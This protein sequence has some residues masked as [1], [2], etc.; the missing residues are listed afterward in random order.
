M[1]LIRN[2]H[3]GNTNK[4]NLTKLWIIN[5]FVMWSQDKMI[6]GQ[7]FEAASVKFFFNLHC[8]RNLM[9][10]IRTSL[11]LT[12]T[13][14]GQLQPTVLEKTPN[15]GL[16]CHLDVWHQNYSTK[17]TKAAPTPVPFHF[18]NRTHISILRHLKT[19]TLCLKFGLVKKRRQQPLLHMLQTFYHLLEETWRHLDAHVAGDDSGPG[20]CC[21]RDDSVSGL[22]QDGAGFLTTQ[23]P[24][25]E[26]ETERGQRL[27]PSRG[28]G[29]LFEVKTVRCENAFENTAASLWGSHN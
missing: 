17:E 21:Q 2:K 3:Y 14:E 5:Q 6:K 13:E 24:L 16:K 27:K 8:G 15:C 11:R 28:R 25:R 22:S 23:D 29:D 19:S 7:I 26:E 1:F 4:T 20:V 9:K 18:K 10:E 12:A